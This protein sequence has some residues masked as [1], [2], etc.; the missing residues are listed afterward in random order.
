M[1][2]NLK[3]LSINIEAGVNNSKGYFGYFT[4]IFRNFFPHSNEPLYK[5]AEYINKLKKI[6]IAAAACLA[7]ALI[8]FVAYKLMLGSGLSSLNELT[9]RL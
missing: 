6:G 2:K 4:T 9:G 1:N 8:L 5:L 7:L 3:V